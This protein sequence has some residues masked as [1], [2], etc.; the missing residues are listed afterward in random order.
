[1]AGMVPG[2]G[3]QGQ[4]AF[5]LPTLPM[6]GGPGADLNMMKAMIMPP[7]VGVGGDK[8]QNPLEQLLTMLSMG[9]KTRM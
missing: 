3:K 7:F 6:G 1:M 2:T 8:G 5:G 9:N 4:G